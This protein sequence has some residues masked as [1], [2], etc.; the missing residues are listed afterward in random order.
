M[1]HKKKRAGEADI[2]ARPSNPDLH[3]T[4]RPRKEGRT[5]LR[6]SF[7]YLSGRPDCSARASQ[8]INPASSIVFPATLTLAEGKAIGAL[9]TLR[10]SSGETRDGEHLSSRLHPEVPCKTTFPWAGTMACVLWRDPAFAYALATH[11]QPRALFL[12]LGCA[13]QYIAA[14]KF[15]ETYIP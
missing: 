11:P 14:K 2:D 6:H 15:S 8:S 4:Q 3:S 12:E 1:A 13:V 9:C 7:A 10:P 5:K